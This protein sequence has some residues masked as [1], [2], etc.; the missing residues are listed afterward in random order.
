MTHLFTCVKVA[1][2]GL[3]KPLEITLEDFN[4]LTGYAT[5]THRIHITSVDLEYTVNLIQWTTL[6]NKLCA[7][8][9]RIRRENP[10]IY[11]IFYDHKMNPWYLNYGAYQAI[12]AARM[13]FRSDKPFNLKPK[14]IS[15]CWKKCRIFPICLFFHNL[16]L[17]FPFPYKKFISDEVV[18]F[19]YQLIPMRCHIFN[20]D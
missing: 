8:F 2:L 3:R 12:S 13:D 19:I 20:T 11:A 6:R 7:T 18:N 15:M 10:T 14:R 4:E 9:N 5:T 16:Y 17:H 1:S